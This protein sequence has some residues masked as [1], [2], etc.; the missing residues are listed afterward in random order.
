[1]LASVACAAQI[2]QAGNGS[3]GS[4]R[5]D[6]ANT[7]T[8]VNQR[9]DANQ[10]LEINSRWVA[11]RK[12]AAINAERKRE[13]DEDSARL[14]EFAAELNREISKGADGGLGPEAMARAAMIEKLAHAVQEKMKLTVAAP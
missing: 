3:N 10:Q 8:A 4:F 11:L 1:M 7:V 13:M 6:K 5:P 9:P 12:F 2:G 14:L